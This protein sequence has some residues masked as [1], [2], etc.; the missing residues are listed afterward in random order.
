M[1]L[2]D[3]T[4]TSSSASGLFSTD[5]ISPTIV[6]QLPSTYTL[7][8][9]QKSDYSRGFLDCLRVLTTVGDITEAQWDERYEWIA[10]QG[11]GGYYLLVIDDGERV[12]GTG[13]LIVERKL[14]VFFSSPARL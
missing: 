12:V 13:A 2:P 7:R 9:L 3:I 4:L 11:K 10:S 5:L 6:A 1:T 8:A 14:C